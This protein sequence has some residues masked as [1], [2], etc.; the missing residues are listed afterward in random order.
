MNA[1]FLRMKMA[2]RGLDAKALAEKLDLSES[3]VKL[4]TR[5]LAPARHTIRLLALVLDCSVVELS[6]EPDRNNATA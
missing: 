2:E 3:Y 1:A 5:G 4:M 6:K